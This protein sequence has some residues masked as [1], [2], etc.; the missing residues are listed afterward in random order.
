M[1]PRRRGNK[2]KQATT[3][4][5]A[6]SVDA[7]E[8]ASDGL[9]E[10]QL[11][12]TS[13]KRRGIYECDYCHTD[14]SQVP[15]I[16]CAVCPDFD[17]CLE[18]FA[19]TDHSAAISR[20][21]AAATAYGAL[22]DNEKQGSVPGISVAAVNHVHT[23]GYRV[24]DSTRYA[25]FPTSRALSQSNKSDLGDALDGEADESDIKDENDEENDVGVEE[26]E[27]EEKEEPDKSPAVD[28]EES[29]DVELPTGPLDEAQTLNSVDMTEEPP[30]ENNVASEEKLDEAYAD[31]KTI[32][33]QDDNKSIWTIEE[34]LR[35]LDAITT[36]GLGNWADISEAIT[37]QGCSSKTPK[38][39]MERYFD[40]FL[41][42]YGHILPLYTI[43]GEAQSEDVEEVE[44][45]ET[46]SDDGDESRAFNKRRKPDRS[47]LMR[48]ASAASNASAS[49]RGKKLKVVPTA[50]LPCYDDIWLDGYI[51]P[52]P[53]AERGV[54]VG[55]DKAVRAELTFVKE[56]T[57]AS[58]KEEADQIRKEWTETRLNQVGGPTALPMRP[59]DLTTLPGSELAGFMPRRGD[60]DMEWENDAE[61]VIADM[62]FSASDLPQDRQLKIQV[63]EIYNQKLDER[64]RRKKFLL[65]RDL[66]DYR[67]N[68]QLDALIPR[69]ER[70]LVRRM[71]LFERLH[72]PEEHKAFV[73]D[74][75]RA[76]R[77]RKEIAK[78]QMYRRMGI[79]TLAEVERYEL[80]KNRREFHKHAQLQKEGDTKPSS[81]VTPAALKL[82]ASKE[83]APAASVVS[84]HDDVTSSLWK[85]YRTSDRKNRRSINRNSLSSDTKQPEGDTAEGIVVTVEMNDAS[86]EAD[87]KATEDGVS[88]ADVVV[89]VETMD[90][91][92]DADPKA[93]EDGDAVAEK[94]ATEDVVDSST[95]DVP[96][97]A[98]QHTEVPQA[99][100]QPTEVSPAEF[101]PTGV[102]PADGQPTEVS[103][104]DFQHTAVSPAEVKISSKSPGYELLST[105]ETEL[106]KNLGLPPL[107][108]LGVKK[109]LIQESLRRGLLDKESLGSS[110][111]SIVKIDVEKR[112]K[113]IDF[114]IRA[115]WISSKAGAS[116]YQRHV[117]SLS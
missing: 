65:N 29:M 48:S 11:V 16:R 10:P 107:H 24:A 5:D 53:R 78:L 102:S 69:D 56:I 30:T 62:E 33:L 21:K 20:L 18:C 13:D 87:P 61:Q 2:G 63:V 68:Q 57:S 41:G 26:K 35:L 8:E 4:R 83:S 9:K 27:E 114:M 49:R 36:Y 22:Q 84:L 7:D 73:G 50:S 47:P 42:R 75:I 72:T 98:F 93:V 66:L 112:G 106:C 94:P 85:Q 86:K 113:V 58:T 95:A 25:L 108:Y 67:K 109:A 43:V 1:P 100:V 115:G 17:L 116:A 45:E 96:P 52:I 59:E 81:Q 14:I 31:A 28:K 64:E 15:R 23:H 89:T 74:I 37:G 97:A 99:A 110:K 70:D 101:Q 34:D 38:R 51:P 117:I 82:S 71:R 60:F 79:K 103:P 55:R 19:T 88:A 105:K 12:L 32:I 40:D 39:C 91:P 104:A 54:E 76:K 77:L 80:D 46:K 90:A 92:E 3:L 44:E 6:T 111:R